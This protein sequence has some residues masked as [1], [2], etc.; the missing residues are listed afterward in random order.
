MIHGQSVEPRQQSIPAAGDVTAR[1]DRIATAGR[2][3]FVESIQQRAIDGPVL[4]A[5]IDEE[6]VPR[7]IESHVIQRG[8]VDDGLCAAVVDEILVAVATR[9]DLYVPAVGRERG[10]QTVGHL[11]RLRWDVHRLQ[12][13]REPA[14][15]E[16]L[17]IAE[18]HGTAS[19]TR[20]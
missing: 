5:G 11:V 17:T 7:W 10:G 6:S 12:V 15:V 3:G 1:P 14:A 8:H 18:N 2:Q 19:T 13:G 9:G 20:N 16:S 4:T